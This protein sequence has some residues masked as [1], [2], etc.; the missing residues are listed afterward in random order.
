MRENLSGERVNKETHAR[1]TWSF[2]SRPE[3]GYRSAMNSSR[4]TDS[5]ILADSSDG[6]SGSDLGLPYTKTGPC[7]TG[8]TDTFESQMEWKK[9][10]GDLTFAAGLTR[11]ANHSGLL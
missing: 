3:S 2:G 8:T 10:S 6:F 5:A 4:T 7:R 11:E 9:H 1:S